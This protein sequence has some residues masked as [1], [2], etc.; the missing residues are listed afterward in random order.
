MKGENCDRQCKLE[1]LAQGVFG[2]LSV[3]VLP[4]QLNIAERN[5]VLDMCPVCSPP[6]AAGEVYR[7]FCP[8]T[9]CRPQ[10]VGW[11]FM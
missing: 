1:A 10:N 8:S 5:A 6:M 2:D 9:S 7:G 3:F 4:V 11:P